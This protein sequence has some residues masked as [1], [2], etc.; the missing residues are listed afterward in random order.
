VTNAMCRR[1]DMLRKGALYGALA[2][3]LAPPGHADAATFDSGSYLIPMDTS[4][5][6]QDNGM[7]RAYGLVYEL[8]RNGVP[9][10]WAIESSKAPNGEDFSIPSGTLQNVESGG[11]IGL[12]RSYRGGP[13]L[14]DA[15]DAAAATPIIAAW[16]A[17][18]SA[19]VV[20]R[21]TAGSFVA[22]VSRTLAYAPRVAMLKDGNEQIGYNNLNAAGIPDL[23]GVAW[24]ATSPDALT[25]V[26][27]VGATDAGATDGALFHSAPAG[28]PRYCHFQAM[29]YIPT[30]ATPNVA[31]E[32]R[33]WLDFSNQQHFYAQ[34]EAARTFENDANGLFVTSA[35]LIDSGLA[36]NPVANQMPGDALAQVDGLFS[37]DSGTVDSIT[38]AVDSTFRSGTRTLFNA[39]ASPLTSGIVLLDGPMDGSA[40][41]GRVTY[42]AGHDYS[43]ML[44]I[45]T[46]S[47]TNGVRLFLNALLDSRCSDTA[48]Q[49]DMVLTASAPAFTNGSLITYTLDYSNPG[50]RPVEAVVLRNAVPAGTSFVSATGG[51]VESGGVVRWSLGTLASGASGSRQF[52]VGVSADGTLQ[53]EAKVDFA[54]LQVRRVASNRV[55]TVRDTV[56]PTAQV[57]SGPDGPTSDATPSFGFSV[58]GSP[59]ASVCRIDSGSFVPCASD[60][61]PPPLAEGPHTFEVRVTD[62]A[63][64][65]GT[66]TRAFSVDL[67]AP[68]VT[69]IESVAK[70]SWLPAA[71]QALDVPVTKVLVTVGNDL[72]VTGAGSVLA[73][74]NWRI[75]SAGANQ[76]LE[77]T[78]CAAY[79][80][81]DT[82]LAISAIEYDP[83]L[84]KAALSV[85]NGSGLQAGKYRL[86]ACPT[87]TDLAGNA[88]DGAGD[89]GGAEAYVQDFA[90]IASPRVFNPNFDEDLAGW[91]PLGP[92]PWAYL[93]ADGE[94]QPFSG[95]ARI[96]TVSGAG[97]T[98]YLEQCVTPA[99]IGEYGVDAL[100][101]IAS[102]TP[103]EP[104]VRVQVSW[105]DAAACSGN[106]TGA[107]S[108]AV[109]AGST[110]GAWQHL[111]FPPTTP[112]LGTLSF[113]LS[114]K[115]L[116]GVAASYTVDVDRVSYPGVFVILKDGFESP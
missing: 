40:A 27:L 113:L 110:A 87:L 2:L 74:A 39:S 111:M 76:A 61:T 24:N 60:F 21:L 6:G 94:G 13:F 46:N 72:S 32:V 8:L 65:V 63:G 114:V 93:A 70:A 23:A 105:S 29:H 80:G 62:A 41:N 95:A 56:P 115:V 64:N 35:Q 4:A 69:G 78:S 47:Q 88:L 5:N 102:A 100:V 89:G 86:F 83:G 10:H 101:R 106:L 34:C 31:R 109:V 33:A 7:L 38:L 3:G 25:E 26:D 48:V 1:Q 82:A 58:G 52:T 17:S 90:A 98:W 103:A 75:A 59:E 92:A 51:G 73:A 77:S 44:P 28:L 68:R 84:G 37:A 108:G 15:A 67:T 11:S 14:I 116:G 50:L 57:T 97:A 79:G 18:D 104:S 49:D 22:P 9:V 112:P 107:N 30:A 71:A 12:P 66:A 81:D 54:H 96:S 19:T 20:H 99:Q 55:T 16:L 85:A 43:L 53:N 42:L 45:S 91:T 36:P